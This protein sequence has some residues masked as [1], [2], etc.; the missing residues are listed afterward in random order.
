MSTKNAEGYRD[1]T[2]AGAI[3]QIER[4]NTMQAYEGEIWKVENARGGENEVLLLKCFENYAAV[5]RLTDTKPEEN[6]V[7]I[8]SHSLKWSDCGKVGY[9]F[10]NTLCSF[11]RE[12]SSAEMMTVRGRVAYALGFC[13]MQTKAEPGKDEMEKEPKQAAAEVVKQVPA[14]VQ[15]G[16]EN[17]EMTKLRI[18]LAATEAERNVYKGLCEKLL[19][20]A[21]E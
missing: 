8:R 4:K 19:S 17:E 11:V 7:E 14:Q 1:P 21:A 13:L 15:S 20:R 18:D 3:K 12:L 16:S 2:A 10:Y 6:S 5:L 9:S